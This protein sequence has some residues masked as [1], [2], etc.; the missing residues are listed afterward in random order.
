MCKDV[1]E[2]IILMIKKMENQAR[3]ENYNK[4]SNGNSKTEK[5]TIRINFT[6][7]A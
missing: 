1:K 4:K 3:N 2:K 5:C 7:W 6:G